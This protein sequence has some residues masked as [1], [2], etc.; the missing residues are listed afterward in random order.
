MN[1]EEMKK[2]VLDYIEK[3]NSVSYTELQRLFEENDYDFVGNIMSCSSQ[4]EHVVFWYGWNG[5]TFDMLTELMHEEKIH[6]EP[7]VLLTYLIDGGALDLPIVKKAIQY[8][9]DHWFPL[10]FCKGK[11]ETI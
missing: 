11:E 5:D 2:A 4:C 3:N 6:R 7:T 1:R 9:T 10:V 8:K